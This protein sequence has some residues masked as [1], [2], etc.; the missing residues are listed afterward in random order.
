MTEPK[1]KKLT[2]LESAIK[3][4]HT[5]KKW[6]I[7]VQK[8]GRSRTEKILREHFDIDHSVNVSRV[9]RSLKRRNLL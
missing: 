8:P 9:V 4:I 7:F 2:P 6:W 3:E 1:D 5:D